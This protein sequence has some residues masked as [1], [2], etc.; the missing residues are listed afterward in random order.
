MMDSLVI[1]TPL[2][3]KEAL[4]ERFLTV[5]LIT[6]NLVKPLVLED[7]MLSATEETSPA[8]WHLAHTTW[9]FENFILRPF[10]NHYSP[11]RDEYDFLFNSYYK[12]AGPYLDKEKRGLLSRPT[13]QEIFEYRRLVTLRIQDL[14]IENLSPDVFSLVEVGIQHEQQHQELLL[15]D[16]KRNFYASPLKPAYHG[17]VSR[18]QDFIHQ[19]TWVEVPE[20]LSR[21]GVEG[22]SPDFSFDNERGAHFHWINPALVSNHLV[23]NR[24]FLEF[25]QD[26][27]YEEPRLWLSDGWEWKQKSHCSHPLYWEKLDGSWFVFTLNGLLPLELSAPVC[28]VSYYEAQAF[29]KWKRARLPTEFE[30]ET[31]AQEKKIEGNFLE[32]GDL[33]PLPTLGPSEN[34][35]QIHGT[36]WEWTQSSYL[37]YPGFREFGQGL[38]EYNGKFMCNQQVL[39]GGSCVT[40]RSHYRVTYRNFYYPHQRWQYAGIRLAKDCHET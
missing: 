15:M 8:K 9:F 21:I 28:H 10:E 31:L 34:L 40:P 2:R 22:E 27:G 16:I 13:V 37:P 1:E 33:E 12:G 23:T 24:E 20:G 6:E 18:G 7:Y 36:L 29:A 4:I 39:R 32:N 19:T 38:G 35:S 30:W 5:R 14:L 3:E 26:G 17:N 11:F 25:I